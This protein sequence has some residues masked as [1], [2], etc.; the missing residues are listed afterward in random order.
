[1]AE[2]VSESTSYLRQTWYHKRRF[3][4]DVTILCQH[5]NDGEAFLQNNYL[6]IAVLS[7]HDPDLFRRYMAIEQDVGSSELAHHIA[8]K[9]M[10]KSA[11]AGSPLSIV[12][13]D[14]QLPRAIIDANRLPEYALREV[15]DYTG[16]DDIASSYRR[17]HGFATSEVAALLQRLSPQGIVLDVHSMAPHTPIGEPSSPDKP[18]DLSPTTLDRYVRSYTDPAMRGERRVIDIVT[19]LPDGAVIADH[20]LAIACNRELE[21]AG[22]ESRFDHPYCTNERIMTTRYMQRHRT[23]AIDV[24]KD[25]LAV[26]PGSSE[27]NIA[28]LQPDHGKV[29][30]VAS[31]IALA[32][33]SCLGAQR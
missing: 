7:R 5:G 25:W 32:V 30:R 26:T 14:V 33:L 3:P 17:K 27:V 8:S 31:P 16:H 1:M 24:P 11:E 2:L 22:L 12:V 6:S 21:V 18:V 4:I 28:N 15:F 10:R 9:L 20:D 23:L 29:Y 19:R 13:L